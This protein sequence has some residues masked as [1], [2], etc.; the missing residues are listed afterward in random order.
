[1]RQLVEDIAKALVD[2]P[3]EVASAR[4]WAVGYRFGTAGIASDLAK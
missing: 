2:I 1:M 4:Y 3:D